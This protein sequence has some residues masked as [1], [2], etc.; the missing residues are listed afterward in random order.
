MFAKGAIVVVKVAFKLEQ[1]G[2]V[3]LQMLDALA[4]HVAQAFDEAPLKSYGV[5]GHDVVGDVNKREVGQPSA[6]RLRCGGR[7]LLLSLGKALLRSLHK[8]SFALHDDG[9][10]PDARRKGAK[11][12]GNGRKGKRPLLERRFVF[13]SG[14]MGG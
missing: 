3:F 8:F 14:G 7:A 2:A 1:K 12:L 9:E 5:L 11:H 13:H 10:L 4:Q 6:A